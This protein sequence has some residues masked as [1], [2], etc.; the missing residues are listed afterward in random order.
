[1]VVAQD[2]LPIKQA[3]TTP[4]WIVA[5]VVL[6]I[7][8]VL[9]GIAGG[10]SLG[11]FGG[12]RYI[13][14]PYLV[15]KSATS[16]EARL[17]KAGLHVK[18][19]PIANDNP[20]ET[21]LVHS[22]NPGDEVTVK[23]GQLVTLSVYGKVQEEVVPSVVGLSLK[24]AKAALNQA[25]LHPVVDV[26]PYKLN[27]KIGFV[28]A[29]SATAG[30]QQLLGSPITITVIGTPEKETVPTVTPGET[31]A[32]ASDALGAAGFQVSPTP[33]GK[34]SNTVPSG[35]VIAFSPPSGSSL[36]QGTPVTLIISKGA[37]IAVPNLIGSS[38]SDAQATLAAIGLTLSVSTTPVIEVNPDFSGVIVQQN[39]QPGSKLEAGNAVTVG[40]GE[41]VGSTTTSTFPAFPT[42]T[43]TF[44]FST[45]TTTATSFPSQSPSFRWHGGRRGER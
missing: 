20:A 14:I 36:P 8:I 1:V 13:K 41:Y 18:L 7:A 44:P 10:R 34:F 27:S 11:Y 45:S 43:T 12:A 22:T 2:D 4:Y 21:G 32:V 35:D 29:Q 37:P 30:I 5:A 24:A 15:G 33:S 3:T 28:T 31:T 42:T 39:P 25:H 26:V 6:L 19:D 16:A 40:I 9:V 23:T 17:N 38:P